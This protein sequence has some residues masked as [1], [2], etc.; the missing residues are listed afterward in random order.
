[1]N[2][3]EEAPTSSGVAI[4]AEALATARE[5][6]EAVRIATADLPLEAEPLAFLTALE[7]LAEEPEA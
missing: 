5:L 3:A 4:S 6:A 7:H 1:M 2:G